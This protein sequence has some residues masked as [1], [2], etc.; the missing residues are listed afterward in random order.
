MLPPSAD[1]SAAGP[2]RAVYRP[3]RPSNTGHGNGASSTEAVIVALRSALMTAHARRST[4]RIGVVVHRARKGIR[5]EAEEGAV[6]IG[7]LRSDRTAILLITPTRR[8]L[9]ALQI[10]APCGDNF[11]SYPNCTLAHAACCRPQRS[12]RTARSWAAL[13]LSQPSLS[14][15]GC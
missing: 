5:K 7:H 9:A 6:L 8:E 3:L 2:A 15:V 4:L 11:R 12:C 10:P 14:V 1:L 13:E